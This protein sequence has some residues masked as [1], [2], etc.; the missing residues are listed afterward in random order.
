MMMTCY[1]N[2]E[3]KLISYLEL[4]KQ[5]NNTIAINFNGIYFLN[6]SLNKYTN[7]LWTSKSKNLGLLM[8][9]N[10]VIWAVFGSINI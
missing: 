6:N 3:Y 1:L 7:K 2:V 4:F 10:W 5:D 9:K 8:K